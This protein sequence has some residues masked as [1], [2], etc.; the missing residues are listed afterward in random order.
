M[1]V[2]AKHTRRRVYMKRKCKMSARAES[3][4]SDSIESG[5]EKLKNWKTLQ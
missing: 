2:R 1:A 5:R 3:K 4:V